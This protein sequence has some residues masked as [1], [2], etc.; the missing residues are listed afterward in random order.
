MC[1]TDLIRIFGC[2]DAKLPPLF[3]HPLRNV[4]Q[5]HKSIVS[6]IAK[7]LPILLHPQQSRHL[8]DDFLVV[9]LT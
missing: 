1:K 4:P 9:F 5:S 6:F 2:S 3:L 7:L 8:F